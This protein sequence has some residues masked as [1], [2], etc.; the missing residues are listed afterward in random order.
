MAQT[1]NVWEVD[2]W[3]SAQLLKNIINSFLTVLARG[4]EAFTQHHISP[5][6]SCSDLPFDLYHQPD[7]IAAL[8][9]WRSSG[10][11]PFVRYFKRTMLTDWEERNYS[12]FSAAVLMSITARFR[13]D[14]RTGIYYYLAPTL[15]ATSTTWIKII[16]PFAIS[17]ETSYPQAQ[18][19]TE[20]LFHDLVD[21]YHSKPSN[22]PQ[23]VH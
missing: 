20:Q 5:S 1:I 8:Q 21:I 7:M 18:A 15:W 14:N 6:G 11:C 3:F 12:H 10:T 9:G 19:P 16:W 22:D 17:S 23:M 13:V 4:N 2:R